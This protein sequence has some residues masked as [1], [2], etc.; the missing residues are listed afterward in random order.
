MP[1]SV[2]KG[3]R[4][5]RITYLHHAFGIV[6]KENRITEPADLKLNIPCIPKKQTG[7]KKQFI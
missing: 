4:A 1:L 7:E 3:I 2:Q 6:A 5:I